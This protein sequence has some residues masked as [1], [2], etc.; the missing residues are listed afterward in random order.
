MHLGF[1]NVITIEN[2]EIIREIKKSYTTFRLVLDP[3]QGIRRCMVAIAIF[4]DNIECNLQYFIPVL[5][6]T[7]PFY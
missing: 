1:P 3:S 4:Y 5:Y 7:I 6:S 2:R